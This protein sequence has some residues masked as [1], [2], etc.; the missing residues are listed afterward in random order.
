[1]LGGHAAT[2]ITHHLCGLPTATLGRALLLDV[3]TMEVS[4]EDVPRLAECAVCGGARLRRLLSPSL[5]A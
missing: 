2:E 1:M 3:R 4:R 5:G